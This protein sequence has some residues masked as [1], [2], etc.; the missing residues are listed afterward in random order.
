MDEK[1]SLISY[2][3]SDALSSSN[4]TLP[5]HYYESSSKGYNY[6]FK[7]VIEAIDNGLVLSTP[8]VHKFKTEMCNNFELTGKCQF[9]ENV[10]I[11]FMKQLFSSP[12]FIISCQCSFAH[13]K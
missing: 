3:R 12:L 5:A 4:R 9:G 2:A 11:L 6:G 7:P 10:R 1:E 8:H 13:G